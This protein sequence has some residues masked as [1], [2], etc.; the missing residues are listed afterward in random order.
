MVQE[1]GELD[2]NV[3]I[4]AGEAVVFLVANDGVCHVVVDDEELGAVDGEGGENVD[5]AAGVVEE[6]GGASALG[7]SEKDFG[8]GVGVV[9]GSFPPVVNVVF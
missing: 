4:G 6:A 8:G 9:H 1:L 7:A 5:D 2:G 3:A